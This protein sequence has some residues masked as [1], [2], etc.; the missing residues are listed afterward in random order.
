MSDTR[1]FG[2]CAI[3]GERRR[4]TKD[5]VPP[6]VARKDRTARRNRAVTVRSLLDTMND[7]DG[8]GTVW[9][10][11]LY[12][13]TICDECNHGRLG[14]EYDPALGRMCREIRRT[15]DAL[16]QGI[17]LPHPVRVPCQPQRVARSI[18]GHL[19]AA[20]P[21]HRVGEKP[22]QSLLAAD[23]R[24]YFL[25]PGA[26]LPR[27]VRIFCW[28]HS[29][30]HTV[31]LRGFL[32]PGEQAVSDLLKFPPLGTLVLYQ[33]KRTPAAPVTELLLD[34]TIGFDETELVPLEMVNPVDSR[35]PEAPEKSWEGSLL[36]SEGVGLVAEPRRFWAKPKKRRD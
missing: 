33:T 36:L 27:S 31:V 4:L 9:Q 16:R 30:R 3:C 35:F 1:T 10:S 22:H 29:G 8:R 25:N 13:E 15:R 5:H 21:E 7:P 14:R 12:F 11:G 2:H 26:S 17:A 32:R 23:L 19:L 24:S 6:T 28:W 20:V 34:R 18:I